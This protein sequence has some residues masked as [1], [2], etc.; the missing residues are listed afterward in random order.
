[1]APRKRSNLNK[2]LPD[3]LYPNGNSYQYKHP[4]TGKRFSMGSD[5]ATAITAAKKL[6]AMFAS[7]TDLVRKVLGENSKTW[8]QLAKRYI[9][10]RQESEGKKASTVREENY[11]LQHIINDLGHVALE[12]TT[13]RLLSDWLSNTYS[14]NP[15]TKHRG[16]LIKLM[17]FGIAKGMFADGTTNLAETTLPEREA[18]KI[19][20]VLTIEQYNAIHEHAEPWLKVAM[21]FSLITLQRLSDVVMTR[22]SDVYSDELRIIQSKTEKYGERAYLKIKIGG[23]LAAVIAQSR[24]VMPVCPFIIHRAPERRVKFEGQE[25]WAQVRNQTLTKEFNKARDKAGIFKDYGKGEAPTYHELRG[26][27][28]ALYLNQGYSKEY[29]NLLMGH[30]T[31]RMTDQ[32]TDQ[33]FEWT[34]CAAELKL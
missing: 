6:N 7:K 29:V 5:K 9:A 25:H 19:R 27:G 18:P 1:M 21:D 31:Q 23:D 34:E 11:R 14:G 12:D 22:Y 3:N 10:E 4:K 30:T 17:S 8:G 33:H 32:Y 26:L 28:G 15:Y 2:D 24:Q 16:T 20:K 13:Q